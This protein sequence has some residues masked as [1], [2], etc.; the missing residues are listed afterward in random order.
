MARKQKWTEERQEV[1]NQIHP[2]EKQKYVGE[3]IRDNNLVFVEG[4]AGSGK[5]MGI[6]Y[7]FVRQYNFDI[8]KEIIIIR[9][10]V[11][12]GGDKIGFLPNDMS[13]KLE[14]HFA[15]TKKILDTLL[16]PGRLACDLD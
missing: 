2:S 16:L 4:P 12:A 13:A 9:T 7:E 6:L 14:P 1:L 15:S 8:T 11:E 3:L 5:T 10:P